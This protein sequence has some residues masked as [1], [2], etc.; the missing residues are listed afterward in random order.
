MS[1]TG[2]TQ[3]EV[4]GPF[5]VWSGMG[6]SGPYCFLRKKVAG[7][8]WHLSLDL[9]HMWHQ[10]LTPNK[11]SMVMSSPDLLGHQHFGP[12]GLEQ[13][14]VDYDWPLCKVLLGRFPK[15]GLHCKVLSEAIASC[16][17]LPCIHVLLLLG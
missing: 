1:D 3:G 8:G 11:H 15:H 4:M 2:V 7:E 9:S 10:D 5:I 6:V 13:T 16:S 12:L 17:S 14:L